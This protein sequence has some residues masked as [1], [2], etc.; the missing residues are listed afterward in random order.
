[1]RKFALSHGLSDR[2]YDNVVLDPRSE[3][4][5]WKA[6]QFDKVQAGTSQATAQVA[7]VLKPGAATERMPEGV[8]AKL[9]FNKD[10][11]AAK[12]SGDKAR[13]IEG[14]L[15]GIFARR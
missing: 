15:E 10:M 4:I 6:M 11:K 7:K 2:E 12:T 5:I 9:Q 13:V 3:S 1:M 8:K 14:R